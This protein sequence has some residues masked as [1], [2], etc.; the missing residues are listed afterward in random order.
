MKMVTDHSCIFR[1]NRNPIYGRNPALL[2]ITV[3]E[4]KQSTVKEENG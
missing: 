4:K 1:G 2:A 3:E